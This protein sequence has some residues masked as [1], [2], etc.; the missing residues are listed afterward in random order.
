[1]SVRAEL[2][3]RLVKVPGL[4]PRPSRRGHGDTYFA[5][6]REIAHFHGDERLDVGL[7]RDAIRQRAPEHP[8]DERVRTRGATADWVAVRVKEDR[9]VSLA[10]SLVRE[11][12]RTN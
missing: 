2:E 5:G 12:I 3:R 8:F 9:D 11:A 4:V 1:M 6:D 10:L 7:T